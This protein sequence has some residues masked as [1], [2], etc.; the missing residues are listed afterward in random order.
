MNGIGQTP[1]G[2]VE[3]TWVVI[4]FLDDENQNPIML[5]TI[6]GIP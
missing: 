1:I 6:G 3:G 5:G 4:T 2:P